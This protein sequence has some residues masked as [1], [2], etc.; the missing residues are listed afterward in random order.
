[1]LRARVVNLLP[2]LIGLSAIPLSFLAAEGLVEKK[3]LAL[4]LVLAV[5]AAGFAVLTIS[6]GPEKIF[7]AWLFFAPFLQNSA[8]FS[9]AGHRLSQW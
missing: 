1:M 2:V 5:L 9:T 8:R 4:M 6:L 3:R 7:V